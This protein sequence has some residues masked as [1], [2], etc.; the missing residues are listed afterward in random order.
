MRAGAKRKRS[1]AHEL[2]PGKRE[3]ARSSPVDLPYQYTQ[4]L[5][6]ATHRA[7]HRPNLEVSPSA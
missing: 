6:L 4:E 7:R 2:K 1:E 3:G 5:L